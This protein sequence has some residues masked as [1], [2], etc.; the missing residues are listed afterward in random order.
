[1]A[2]EDVSQ[3]NFDH[4]IASYITKYSQSEYNADRNYNMLLASDSINGI[5]LQPGEEF[6]YNDVILS[7]RTPQRDY[8]NAP[9]ISNGEMVPAI[10]GGI[11]Q[12]STT[13]FDA[14]LYSGMTITSR[15]NH[16]LMVGYV[17]AGWDATVSWGTI[18]FKFR[19]DLK[20]PVKIESVMKDGTLK[21]RFLSPGDPEI[22]EIKVF[23]SKNSD[24]SYTLYRQVDGVIDYQTTSRY[25]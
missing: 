7:K 24:G 18:D 9:I 13:L 4:D 17:P 19:N 22:G 10:G 8:K 25:R 16:S 1:M 14:A 3:L 2:Q 6:S 20:L 12:I 21:I 23:S 5:I 11:C 15:R